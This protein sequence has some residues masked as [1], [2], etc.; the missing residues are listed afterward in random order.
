MKTRFYVKYRIFK[1]ADPA[2]HS[3]F[4]T[5]PWRARSKSFNTREEAQAWIK[6][7]KL[8]RD[9]FTKIEEQEVDTTLLADIFHL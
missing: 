8:N 6:S 7:E 5:T 3:L 1:E 2:V 4:D 9:W